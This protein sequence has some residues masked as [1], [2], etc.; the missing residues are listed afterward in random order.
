MK[1][2]G[3][4]N[5]PLAVASALRQ[6]AGPTPRP[7]QPSVPHK[8][9]PSLR[10]VEAFVHSITG[11]FLEKSAALIE[12]HLPISSQQAF[13]AMVSACFGPHSHLFIC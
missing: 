2:S 3:A 6:Q 9:P 11:G 5:L 13:S 7:G 12:V 1:M 4:V 10:A 8:E